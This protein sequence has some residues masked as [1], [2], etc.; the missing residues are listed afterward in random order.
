MMGHR[1]I[2]SL[3]TSAV[4]DFT[5]IYGA[6][7]L[8]TLNSYR[9]TTQSQVKMAMKAWFLMLAPENYPTPEQHLEGRVADWPWI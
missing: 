6:L 1:W 7:M 8:S 3:K 9:S 5:N 4:V 2:K